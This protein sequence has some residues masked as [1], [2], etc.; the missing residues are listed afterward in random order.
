MR[1]ITRAKFTAPTASSNVA[2]TL[3][4]LWL[5]NAASLIAATAWIFLDPRLAPHLAEQEHTLIS[6]FRHATPSLPEPIDPYDWR[7]FFR[8]LITCLALG[9]LLV[10]I[11]ALFAGPPERRR[12]R[13]WLGLTTLVAL[14]LGLAVSWRDLSWAGTRWRLAQQLEPFERL[15]AALSNSWP[16]QDGTV[17]G[18]GQ[19]SA[20]PARRPRTLLMIAADPGATHAPIAA[21]E[22]STDGALCFQLAGKEA[23]AW[24]EWHPA[25]G[26]PA[27]FTGGLEDPHELERASPLADH[28]FA[29]RYALPFDCVEQR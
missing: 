2:R 7:W 24:L 21:V 14:W 25:G 4:L 11:I 19:F 27:S 15:A 22:R 28:W 17:P 13:S 1:L 10:L 6:N 9:S 18:L 8:T 20:Y 26:R 29:T 16:T 23:G 5:V 12:V 3:S